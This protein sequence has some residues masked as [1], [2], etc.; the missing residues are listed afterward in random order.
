MDKK[1][2]IVIL[3]VAILA[4][5]FSIFTT[6]NVLTQKLDLNAKA[7]DKEIN[8]PYYQIKDNYYVSRYGKISIDKWDEIND[9]KSGFRNIKDF[10]TNVDNYVNLISEFIVM[11]DWIEQHKEQYREDYYFEPVIEFSFIDNI[12]AASYSDYNMKLS[13]TLNKELFETNYSSLVREITKIIARKSVADSLTEGLAYYVQDE[14]GL[15]VN[16]LNYGIDIFTVSKK[17]L[18]Q[19]YASIISRIGLSDG[20][21]SLDNQKA[22]YILSNSF[23]RYLI[24]HYGMDKYI[25]VYKSKSVETAYMEIYGSTVD[26]LKTSWIDYVNNYDNYIKLSKEYISNKKL[27]KLIGN[28]KYTDELNGNIKNKA[29]FILDKSFEEYLIYQF[30]NYKHDMLIKSNYD[31]QAIYET[32]L[33][34]LKNLWQQYVNSID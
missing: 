23:S 26:E 31:Y 16:K 18:S 30:G 34:E 1:Y 20:N 4:L 7:V 19:N 29:F 32:S 12:K 22:F 14:L 24:Q 9:Q 6:D 27:I 17:Y 2:T 8:N 10:L 15:N 28:E 3:L 21:I 33:N 13:V 11:P 5:V 25:E